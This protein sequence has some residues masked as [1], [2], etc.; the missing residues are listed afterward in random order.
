MRI[1]IKKHEGCEYLSSVAVP[2]TK[3]ERMFL[4]TLKYSLL[5]EY[6]AL[7]L[8]KAPNVYRDMLVLLGYCQEYDDFCCI[9][10]PN[11]IVIA[12]GYY[13]TGRYRKW[14]MLRKRIAWLNPV[15]FHNYSLD[16]YSEHLD[17]LD[18]LMGDV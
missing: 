11:E 13:L 17:Y 1:I 9:V 15:G 7:D 16:E 14:A 12:L 8:E 4:D 6:G 2:T 5:D 10:P 3:Q 18:S